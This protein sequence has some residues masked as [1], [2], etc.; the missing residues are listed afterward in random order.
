MGGEVPGFSTRLLIVPELGL[1]VVLMIN[2]KDP[3]LAVGVFDSLLARLAVPRSDVAPRAS[4]AGRDAPSID[5]I[6]G[7]YRGNVYERA[8]F[9]RIGALLG[10]TLSVRRDTGETLV[11]VNPIDDAAG[12]WRRSGDSIWT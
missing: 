1:G 9:L 5:E 6:E 3:T 10:P 4:D 8:S 11:V 2:R 7:L 12:R